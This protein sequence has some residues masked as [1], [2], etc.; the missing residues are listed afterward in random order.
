VD[1]D[2]GHTAID[3][4]LATDEQID[5]WATDNEGNEAQPPLRR[6]VGLC[7][8][9][10]AQEFQTRGVPSAEMLRRLDAVIDYARGALPRLGLGDL[11]KEH[12]DEDETIEELE[13]CLLR[14]AVNPPPSLIEQLA[15]ETAL[16]RRSDALRL[17]AESQSLLRAHA[18]NHLVALLALRSLQIEYTPAAMPLWSRRRLLTTHRSCSRAARADWNV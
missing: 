1:V 18:D 13:A 8:Q 9:V 16:R 14:V 11:A 2:L 5:I 12:K 10:R 17:A 7:G 6:V 3:R 4:W 15:R